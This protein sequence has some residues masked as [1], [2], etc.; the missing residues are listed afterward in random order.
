MILQQVTASREHPPRAAP[1]G[2]RT[3]SLLEAMPRIV[4][5]SDTKQTSRLLGSA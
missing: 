4:K 5:L 2:R 3:I 1:N